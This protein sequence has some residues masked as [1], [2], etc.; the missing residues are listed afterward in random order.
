MDEWLLKDAVAQRVIHNMRQDGWVQLTKRDLLFHGDLLFIRD[1]MKKKE[2]LLVNVEKS[3]K[4]GA[5]KLWK[6]Y[7]AQAD[8][9]YARARSAVVISSK[10]Q[11][12]PKRYI[13][14]SALR[15]LRSMR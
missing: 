7:K 2:L 9:F 5:Y 3:A 1:G 13:L 10:K 15:R 12:K 6:K 8:V 11:C 14:S 4:K